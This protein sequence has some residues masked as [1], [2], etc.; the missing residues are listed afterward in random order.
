[1]ETILIHKRVAF[2]KTN[3]RVRRLTCNG[4]ESVFQDY[5]TN[6]GEENKYT[7]KPPIPLFP[8]PLILS[9]IYSHCYLLSPFSLLSTLAPSSN[10]ILVMCSQVD[11]NR[12][13]ERFSEQDK[14]RRGEEKREE[15][16]RREKR[17]GVVMDEGGSNF[18][19]KTVV[20]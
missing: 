7:T 18:Q 16:V 17:G 1:M 10:L 6:L 9:P 15:E 2:K 4:S 11:T 20:V 14:L 3:E 13:P 12:T 8:C 5:R 19:P